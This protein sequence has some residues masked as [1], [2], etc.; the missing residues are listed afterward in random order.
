[1]VDLNK[2]VVEA[3]PTNRNLIVDA[4]ML[5]VDTKTGKPLPFGTMGI[6]KK[7]QFADAVVCLFVFDCIYYDDRSLMEKSVFAVFHERKTCVVE[8]SMQNLFSTSL[9]LC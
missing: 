1:M 8:H 6:H 3:F 4:E 7:K 9:F 2:A 5:L